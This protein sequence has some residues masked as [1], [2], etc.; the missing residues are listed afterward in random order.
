MNIAIP[1]KCI[2]I[3]SN[4]INQK[5]S[6]ELTKCIIYFIPEQFT[7]KAHPALFEGE[8]EGEG[9]TKVRNNTFIQ[10]YIHIHIQN[11]TKQTKSPIF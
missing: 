3:Y 9:Q 2:R 11:H 4:S 1:V 8:G 6:C 5:L 10:V 7:V